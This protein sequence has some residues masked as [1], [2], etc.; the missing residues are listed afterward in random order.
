M[1]KPDVCFYHHPCDDGFGSALIVQE[2]WPECRMFGVAYGAPLPVFELQDRNLLVVDF[3]FK[4]DVLA[5]LAEICASIVILDHHKSAEEDLRHV[6]RLEVCDHRDM[7]S[8]ADPI[9]YFDMNKSGVRLAWEFCNPDDLVPRFFA[10]IEDRDLWRFRYPETRRF[11]LWLRSFDMTFDAWKRAAWEMQND[12]R[13]VAHE[14]AV[15]ERYYDRQIA[16]LVEGAEVRRFGTYDDVPVAHATFAFASDLGHALLAA[17]PQASFAAVSWRDKGVLNWSLRSADD[18]MDV[19]AVAR[20]FG[21]G[22]HR[23]AAGFREPT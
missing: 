23:N 10:L 2:K 16:A 13:V 12:P 14:A 20:E 18:R 3:S 7:A 15:I 22:G 8:P 5:E 19:S 17:H 9:A 1:W 6:A 11:S 21:G 4:P